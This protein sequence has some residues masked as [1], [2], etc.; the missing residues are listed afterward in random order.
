MELNLNEK[1]L[2]Q[3]YPF[4]V[5]INPEGHVTCF[6]RSASKTFLNLGHEILASEIFEIISPKHHFEIKDL[7]KIVGKLISLKSK[8]GE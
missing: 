7:P 8:T 1:H 5:G 2:N 6:G 4:Y 3:L